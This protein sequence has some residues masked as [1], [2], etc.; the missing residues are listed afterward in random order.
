MEKETSKLV[1]IRGLSKKFGDITAVDNISLEVVKN[2][3]ICLLGPSGCGKTTTMRVV[4]GLEKSSGGH[5]YIKG[6]LIDDVPS[7][8]RN[9]GMVFQ[10][11]ALFPHMNIYSNVAF[12]LKMRKLRERVI[13]N[14]VGAVLELVKL[15]G[16]E[17]RMVNQLS[18]GQQQRVALA[19]ALAIEPEILLL[20]EPLSNLDA[21]L[22]VE[23]RFELKNLV[24]EL[25]ITTIY[26]THDQEEALAIADKIVVMNEGRIEQIGLPSEL[27]EQPQ[28]IFIA[29]FIGLS[30]IIEGYLKSVSADGDVIVSVNAGVE[31]R[32]LY[33]DF[34]GLLT[35]QKVNIV[36]RPE[37]IR[38][39]SE[40][41]ESYDNSV[42][43]TIKNILYLGNTLR[44]YV[45]S[46]H[47]QIVVAED[48][49]SG[50]DQSVLKLGENVYMNWSSKKCLVFACAK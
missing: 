3:I 40:K 50:L 18:G 25:G 11:Y 4:A 24:H 12:G 19:R 6:V 32:G 45:E 5:I 10:N 27:Y 35:G 9:I 33:K 8:K 13:K 14:K 48:P 22:R 34:K 47:G 42:K 31:V 26:V 41:M 16:F 23:M 36:V 39:S 2:E 1:E 49:L 30:N 43:G 7:Y 44:Y 28:N 46:L 15:R 20:D 21:K 29:N 17:N 38:V 37:K